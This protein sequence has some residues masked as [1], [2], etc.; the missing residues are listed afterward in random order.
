MYW[1][2]ISINIVCSFTVSFH[3]DMVM[4][5]IYIMY[6]FTYLYKPIHVYTSKG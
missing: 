3:N 5:N 6:K 4:L 2:M 1:D